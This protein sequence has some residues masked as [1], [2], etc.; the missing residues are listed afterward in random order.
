MRCSDMKKI[1][2]AFPDDFT[3]EQQERIQK[4]RRSKDK[5]EDF[6][7]SLYGQKIAWIILANVLAEYTNRFRKSAKTFDEAWDKLGYKTVS[8]IVFRSVNGLPCKAKDT[9]ELSDFI[10]KSSLT[11]SGTQK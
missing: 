11:K 3:P 6:F 10:K 1:F 2:R 5:A 7:I 9:G 8:E 4:C